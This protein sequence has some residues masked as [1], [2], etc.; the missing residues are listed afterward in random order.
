MKNFLLFTLALVFVPLVSP[1]QSGASAP[2]RGM[3]AAIL[4]RQ[5]PKTRLTLA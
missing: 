2:G 3:G 4:H 1:A 5:R